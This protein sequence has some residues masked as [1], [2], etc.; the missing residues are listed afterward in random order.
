MNER[1]SKLAVVHMAVL[2]SLPYF[3][4]GRL[5]WVEQKA[6]ERHLA[7]CSVCRDK[8]ADLEW[9]QRGCDLDS[10][11]LIDGA[12]GGHR[13]PMQIEHG[14][15]G[16]DIPPA[17][18]LSGEKA[19]WA[20][21]IRQGLD[22]A[23]EVTSSP[24]P[25]RSLRVLAVLLSASLIAG[26]SRVDWGEVRTAVHRA[27]GWPRSAGRPG[28][29]ELRVVFAPSIQID[30]V[31][32]LARELETEIVHGSIESG[33]FTLRLSGVK[34]TEAAVARVIARLRAEPGV[35]FAAPASKYVSPE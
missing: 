5:A 10:S 14:D 23:S 12:A 27:F 35:V 18:S 34:A 17:A 29:G 6:V 9:Q 3:V 25:S 2:E 32:R 7:F 11:P 20:G 4:Q 22:P 13:W 26:A 28:E 16:D 30:Q 15:Q 24:Y 31:E 21:D 1:D 8:L 19:V 33:A